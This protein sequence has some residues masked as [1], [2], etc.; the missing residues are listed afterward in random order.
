[1]M[2]LLCGVIVIILPIFFNSAAGVAVPDPDT[3][4][5]G[6][7]ESQILN[8]EDVAV[9]AE[10]DN[11]FDFVKEMGTGVGSSKIKI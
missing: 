10:L 7:V 8:L 9:Q 2:K 1:M 5:R 3:E 6:L 4:G 11:N